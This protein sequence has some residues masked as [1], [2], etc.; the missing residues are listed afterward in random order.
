MRLTDGQMIDEAAHVVALTRRRSLA[1]LGGA[2]LTAALIAPRHV[3]AGK[4]GKKAKKKVKKTCKRQDN[5]CAAFFTDLC[6]ADPCEPEALEAALACC[7][8]LRTCDAGEFM[9][10]MFDVLTAGEEPE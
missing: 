1:A 2:A 8:I 9:A 7:A 4:A 5:Q 3:K 6:E 10:C